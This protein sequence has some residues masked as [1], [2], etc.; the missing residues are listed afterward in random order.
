[1]IH[2]PW[3]LGVLHSLSGTRT[4]EYGV[5]PSTCIFP[6]SC[7]SPPLRG[8][9]GALLRS[10]VNE[11]TYAG[12]VRPGSTPTVVHL[13]CAPPSY[14]SRR[15]VQPRRNVLSPVTPKECGPKFRTRYVLDIL[16][17]GPRMGG[18]EMNEWA[19]R[20]DYDGKTTLLNLWHLHTF[21]YCVFS[22]IYNAHRKR[23]Q[24]TYAKGYRKLNYRRVEEF[25]DKIKPVFW[26]PWGLLQRS[27][28]VRPDG[29]RNVY[30]TEA[31]SILIVRIGTEFKGRRSHLRDT[32]RFAWR[33]FPSPGARP[34]TWGRRRV[35]VGLDRRVLSV[36]T[37]T[38]V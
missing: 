32:S 23:T 11:R 14:P 19:F 21:V 16:E 7:H 13:F 10:G 4:L 25:Q 17:S 35:L 1:M 6:R 3:L 28:W 8:R 12:D 34:E 24:A 27:P 30:W 38:T 18:L 15:G 26:W 33:K 37:D 36:G 29:R 5:I 9:V 31:S 20:S 22:I 2:G